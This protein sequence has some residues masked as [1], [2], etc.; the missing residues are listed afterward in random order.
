M[1]TSY[2]MVTK[3]GGDKIVGHFNLG[4]VRRVEAQGAKARTMAHQYELQLNN[5]IDYSIGSGL[6]NLKKSLNENSLRYSVVAL[7]D[8]QAREYNSYPQW[9]EC[10]IYH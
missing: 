5:N 8:S 9:M 2:L 7:P 3:W 1:T 4:L 6:E 10:E